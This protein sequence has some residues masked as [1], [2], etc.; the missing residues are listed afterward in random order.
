MVKAVAEMELTI[1]RIA[2]GEPGSDGF[3]RSWIMMF[4]QGQYEHPQYGEL[5]F[6]RERLAR[7]KR[8]F[9]QRVRKI[10]IALDANHVQD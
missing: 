2:L 3:H 5:D 1:R 8:N 4:A 7:I 6:S 10:D 9:D